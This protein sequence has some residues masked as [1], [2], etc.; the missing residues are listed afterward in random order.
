MLERNR[1]PGACTC[2]TTD[3]PHFR[4]K[5]GRVFRL[6]KMALLLASSFSFLQAK[7]RHS[8]I[9]ARVVWG[10]GVG[11]KML[12]LIGGCIEAVA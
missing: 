1:P 3:E 10:H 9:N 2:L 8:G 11:I 12:Q 6:Q 4:G 5:P 7:G